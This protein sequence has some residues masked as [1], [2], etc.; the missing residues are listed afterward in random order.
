MELYVDSCKGKTFVPIPI[1]VRVG[2]VSYRR[3][4]VP[5]VAV[6]CTQH[7]GYAVIQVVRK[8]APPPI[9]KLNLS[10]TIERFTKF[11]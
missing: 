3:D 11:F 1:T 6:F 5:A 7:I 8:N 4:C 2:L 9:F 10:S